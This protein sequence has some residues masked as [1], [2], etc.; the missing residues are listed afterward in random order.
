LVAGATLRISPEPLRDNADCERLACPTKRLRGESEK[1]AVHRFTSGTDAAAP[2]AATRKNSSRSPCAFWKLPGPGRPP[3]PRPRSRPVWPW[4]RES[5]ARPHRHRS[6]T[7]V[8]QPLMRSTRARPR[9]SLSRD[10]QRTTSPYSSN[11]N[12]SISFS[13]GAKNCSH[14]GAPRPRWRIL[15]M[16]FAATR[17]FGARL[18]RGQLPPRDHAAQPI[19]LHSRPLG[20]AG[21]SEK[22]GGKSLPAA[23]LPND[24]AGE[25]A[26]K[27]SSPAASPKCTRI[28][29][30]RGM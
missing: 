1:A 10:L 9:I 27:V 26:A 15:G 23:D 2:S 18:E 30:I 21:G 22:S 6:R 11:R 7:Q 14:H 20:P 16:R 13:P 4:L 12:R 5:F 24:A 3:A 17:P 29:A 28:R 19:S 8:T 25:S